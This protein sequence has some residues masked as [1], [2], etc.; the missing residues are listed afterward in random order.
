MLGALQFTQDLK[1]GHYMKIPP[2]ITF[3]GTYGRRASRREVAADEEMDS[4]NPCS[5]SGMPRLCRREDP[6]LCFYR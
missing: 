6:P 3:F 5:D 2:R 4:A 1:L